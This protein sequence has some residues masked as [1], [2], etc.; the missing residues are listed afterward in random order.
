MVLA[1]IVM[2]CCMITKGYQRGFDDY[3]GA[4]FFEVTRQLHYHC[5]KTFLLE[6]VPNIENV[7]EGRALA[8]V[9]EELKNAG[10][11]YVLPRVV[12]ATIP[13]AVAYRWCFHLSHSALVSEICCLL[14]LLHICVPLSI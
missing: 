14:A 2:R 13:T 9:L 6:N 11:G 3:R 10:T 7:D 12:H 8:L 1:T 4:L 5:P